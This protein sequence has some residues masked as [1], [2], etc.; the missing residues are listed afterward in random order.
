MNKFNPDF[1]G[2]SIMT[3]DYIWACD[4]SEFIKGI[5]N[6]PII[7]EGRINSPIQAKLFIQMGC[8]FVVVGSAITRPHLITKSYVDMLIK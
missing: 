3:D 2:F 7:A 5:K 1:I 8:S 6:I 4:L